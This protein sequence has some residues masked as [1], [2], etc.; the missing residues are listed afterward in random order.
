MLKTFS[1]R[2]IITVQRLFI[3]EGRNFTWIDVGTERWVDPNGDHEAQIQAFPNIM[4]FPSN[5]WG[6]KMMLQ[7]Q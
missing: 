2:K 4:S 7:V 5:H 6:R 1:L 3:K